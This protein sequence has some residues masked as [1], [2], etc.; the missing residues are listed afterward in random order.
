ILLQQHILV[1]NTKVYEMI[2]LHVELGPR[3]QTNAHISIFD[4]CQPDI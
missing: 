4:F 1:L 3:T 2:Y